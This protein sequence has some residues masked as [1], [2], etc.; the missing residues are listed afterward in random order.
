MVVRFMVY[1]K[2]SMRRH[3]NVVCACELVNYFVMCARLN[4]HPDYS[5]SSAKKTS[6][7]GSVTT[8]RTH[9]KRMA[10][11][12]YEEYRCSSLSNNV[13][14]NEAAVPDNVKETGSGQGGQQPITKYTQVEQRP[15]AWD[16]DTS[17]ELILDFVIETDQ[18]NNTLT[19]CNCTIPKVSIGTQRHEPPVIPE[20]D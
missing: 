6:Y 20:D 7:T 17:I 19:N 18:V 8:L 9:I 4:L 10:G 16:K 5:K 14:M 2:R 13:P 15:T 11:E 1:S 3:L 12:H